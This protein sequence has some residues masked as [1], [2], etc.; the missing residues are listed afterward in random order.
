MPR[1]STPEVAAA[2][3]A[4]LPSFI[5]DEFDAFLECGILMLDLLLIVVIGGMGTTCGAVI[6]SARF[7]LAQS[8]LRDLMRFA[9]TQLQGALEGVPML[10]AL[11]SPQ[12][13]PLWMG[14]LFVLSMYHFHSGV[15]G[16]LRAARRLRK[17]ATAI[18][19]EL[20]VGALDR[21][22]FT[23]PLLNLEATKN[24]PV[25]H[26]IS[27]PDN[28]RAMPCQANGFMQAVVASAKP[29]GRWVRLKD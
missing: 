4:S 3:G 26:W 2:S 7:V 18:A 23:L 16:R 8:Y 19:H 25:K 20:Q 6:G 1:P 13:W 9:S 21:I 11:I 29:G 10:A 28:A 24:K 14:I 12:P 27:G 5:K 22:A 15:V 17:S